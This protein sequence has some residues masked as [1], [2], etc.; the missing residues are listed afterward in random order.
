M[1]G[2]EQGH[3]TDLLASYALDAVD[4]PERELIETHLSDCA[5]CRAEA[6][7]FSEMA[8]ALSDGLEVTPPLQIRS[9][10][11]E[12]VASEA[13]V[14]RPLAGRRRR[15]WVWG[16]AAAG[17]VAIGGWGLWQS[18]GED[19]TPV[20]QVIQADDAQRYQA[21]IEEVEVTVV[22]SPA[23]DRAVI[24]AADLPELADDQVYQAWFVRPDGAIDSAGVLEDTGTDAE[25]EG[26]PDGVTAVALSVEPA[27][28]SEQ[29]TTEPLGAIPLES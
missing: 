26:D 25:L 9:R 6:Q 27:G 16:V 4:T 17:V 7:E 10:L 5:Q 1:T 18:V 23:E 20:E 19:L 21:Q 8:I 12:Q 3:V 14:V 29:P 2:Q 22:V 15:S 11:L 24:V 28:G 13:E